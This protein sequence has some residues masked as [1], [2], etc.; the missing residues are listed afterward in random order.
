MRD[1]SGVALRDPS[2]FNASQSA[3]LRLACA[4]SC[5]RTISARSPGERQ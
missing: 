3:A 4:S 1:E 5:S 2:N